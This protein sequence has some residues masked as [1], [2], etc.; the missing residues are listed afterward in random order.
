M[1]RIRGLLLSILI[2]GV[3]LAACGA[4]SPPPTSSSPES[5]PR[6]TSANLRVEIGIAN[7]AMGHVSQQIRLKNIS[8]ATCT[9]RGYPRLQMLDAAGAA[10]TTH[11]HFGADYIVPTIAVR[12][13]T[14]AP[15]ASAG[16]LVGYENATGFATA[17]C[18]TSH[19]IEIYPPHSAS[20]L[21]VRW[22]LAPYG[23]SVSAL[24]CGLLSV[25]P[26]ASV[27]QLG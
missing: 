9:L 6:C 16:F 23:G 17:S 24:N 18:P 20:A 4:A 14:L 3:I 12:T 27:A 10:L 21:S 7:V 1:K 26:I 11:L 13:V 5:L 15:N 22:H 25:S 19:T 8:Q 2:G